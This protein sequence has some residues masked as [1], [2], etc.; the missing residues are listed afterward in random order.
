MRKRG[1]VV[2]GGWDVAY[3]RS[4]VRDMYHVLQSV[5]ALEARNYIHS[6]RTTNTGAC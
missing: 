3:D 5:A 6:H 2:M 4:T 1:D